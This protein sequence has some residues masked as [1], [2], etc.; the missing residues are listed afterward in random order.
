MSCR[1]SVGK[2]TSLTWS[3]THPGLVITRV[4]PYNTGHWYYQVRL[5]QTLFNKNPRKKLEKW[6]FSKKLQSFFEKIPVT[7][8]FCNPQK[9]SE[10]IIR[11]KPV[12]VLYS[13]KRKWNLRKIR[14]LG[15]LKS[16]FPIF[17]HFHGH[18]HS[19]HLAFELE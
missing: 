12:P 17:F 6:K 13:W 4:A 10:P 8:H 7:E 2:N 3:R 11:L 5:Y 16:P 18:Y 1:E 15:T 9:E 19:Q 14:C